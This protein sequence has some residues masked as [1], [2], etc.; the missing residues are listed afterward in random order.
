MGF[1]DRDLNR[2]ILTKANN[3]IGEAITILTTTNYFNDDVQ[4]PVETTTSTFIGPLSKEQLEQQQQQQQAVPSNENTNGSHSVI[5][6]ELT[7]NSFDSFT[8]NA[9]LDL[10]TKVYGDSWSIPYKREEALG[11]C[12]L[13]ATKLAL[14]G[15]ADQDKH[16]LKFMENLIPEAFRKLQ[17]SYH[18]N[19]WAMEIQ[20][21]VFDMVELVVDL[22][23][24]RLAYSPVPVKLLETLTILFDYDSVFQRKHKSKT[25]DRSL[26]DKQL[27]DRTLAS[28][29]SVSAFSVYNRN[30][31]YG[32]LCQ[33]IN[34]FVYKDGLTNLKQQFQN[35][36]PLTALEYNALLSPFV[37]C[38]DYISLDKY[39]QLFGEHIDQALEYIINLK[40]EDFKAKSANSIFE[41]LTTLRNICAAA[42]HNR[43]EQVEQLHLNLLLKMIALSNFNAKMNSLKELAKII[44]NS[45][46]NIQNMSKTSIRREVISDWIIENSILSKALEGNIDQNQYVDKVRTLLDFIATKISKE[47]IETIWKMQHGRSLVAVDHLFTLIASAAA[48]FN[49]QQL[50]YLIE[51]IYDS[52]KIETILI[53]EKLIELLGA[54]GRECQKESAARVLEILWDMAHEEHL[55]RS[56]LDNIL[57]CHLRIFSE[58]RSPYDIL[59]R[60]YCLKC[61]NDLQRKQGWLAPAIKHL[62]DLLRH[63]STNTFKR[64]DQ[65][66]ISV[67]VQNHDLISALIQSLSTCQLD[68]WN[69]TD[70]HVT[71]DTLVDGRY[72]HEESTRNHLDLLSFLLKKGNLFLILKRSEELWDTLITNKHVNSFDHE[73]GLNWFITCLE[74]LN[75]ESQKALFEER[76]SKLDPIH[77]SPKGYACFKL[78]F[79]R[80]ESERGNSTSRFNYNPNTS[81]SINNEM[82]EYY[83]IN[84]LWNIILCVSDDNLANEATRFLLDLYYLKQPNRTRRL[85]ATSLHEYFLK[86]VYTRLS[87]LLNNA[88]PPSTELTTEMEQFYNSLKAYGEQLI[89]T[90]TT[91]I[92]ESQL[93]NSG[94]I[95]HTLWL[96]K[97]ERLLMITEEY[98]HIVEHEHSPTAHI[99]SFYGLEYQIK[100]TLDEIGKAISSYDIVTVHSNDTLEMLR[101]RLGEFYK[102]LSHDIHISIQNTRPLPPSYDHIGMNSNPIALPYSSNN[103]SNTNNNNNNNNNSVLGAWLNSKYLYQVH[104]VPGTTI[105]IKILGGTSNQPI[106]SVN[107]E[108]KRIYLNDS[109]SLSSL[110]NKNTNINPNDDLTRSIPSNMMVENSKIYD[111]LYTLSYLNNKNIHQ[112]IRN[113]LCLIPSDTRTH[114]FLDYISIRAV[115]VCTTERRQSTENSNNINPRQAIEHVFD[116]NNCSFIQLLYNLEILS[117]KILPLST[118]NGIQESSKLFRQDFIEQSGVDFLFQLLNSLTDFISNEYQYTLC[119]EMIIHILQLIQLLVCGNNINHSIDNILSSSTTST[120]ISPLSSLLQMSQTVN[121]NMNETTVD[122]DFQGTVENLQFDTFVEQIKQLIFLCWAAAAGNIKLH[123]QN[124]TI[125]EEVKLDRYTLLQQIN[126]NVINRNNSKNSLS[127]D[128]SADN[129]IQQT[130][131][132]GICVKK[133]SILPLDSEIAEKIIEIIT[134][135]FEKRPEFIATFLIQSFFADYLLEILIGTTSR[136]VRQCAL[137]NINR[138]CKIET[139]TYDIRSIIHQILLKARL[140]LWSSSSSGIRNS[141]QKILTQS[142]EYFDLR[143]QLTENLTIEKQEILNINAKQLLK[144]E[145]T[146]LSTYTVSLTSNE[147]RIIDNILFLGHL[148]FIRTL[149]T[150]ENIDKNE[151]GQDFIRLL[152]D[153][154]LFPASKRM[155]LSIVPSN[156]E[157]DAHDDYACE[158]KCSTSESRLAAYDVLVELVRHCQ[159]NLK[160][161]IE[162]LIDLHHRP[163]LEKQTEWEFMPQVNPRASCGLVGLQNGGATCYMNSILQQLY[164]LPQISEHILS[165]HDDGENSNGKVNKT[166]GEPSLFYQLQQV[167][168]H[169]MESKLQYYSPESL[170]KV[171]RLWGQEINVREQQDAFDFFTAMTDQ[172]DEYLKSIKQEE[173]FHKQFEG[174]FCN[175]MICTNGCRHRYEGEEKF[176]A[177]NVAVK[178]DSL[179]ESLNQFVKGEVLDGTNA[180]FCA[181]CQEKRTTI[182]RLCIKKLPPL[183]CIQMKRFGF[184]WE[185][186]RALKFDDYFK[187]PLILNMEPYTVDG[188]N[189]RES[190]VE[191]DSPVTSTDT[192]LNNDILIN[193][194]KTGTTDDNP[195]L[196][197]TSSSLNN[198][199]NTMSSINYELIGIVI[200]S[201]Q[202]NAGHYYSFIKDTRC[203]YSNNTNQWYRFN[204]TSVEEIQLTEQMLE[205]ECF[206]GTFRVQ[207][208]NHNNS[209]E[210]RTRFWNAYILIYQCIE[211]SKL[212]PPPPSNFNR[213]SSRNHHISRRNQRDSLS[214]LADLVV[215]SEHNDLFQIKKSL[216]PS[217][218]LACVKDENLEFLKNRD[219]YCEDYFRFIYNLS[220]ICFDEIIYETNNIQSTN[221]NISSYKL[222]TKLALNFLF[223]THLRTHRRLRKNTLDDWVQLLSRLFQKNSLS[224]KIFY[225]LLFENEENRLKLYLLDC[226]IYEI[227]QI[228]E[229][230][231]ENILQ[232]SYIHDDQMKNIELFVEQLIILLDKSVVE[233][234]KHSQ[235]YFE[236]IYSYAN[237]NQISIEYLIKLNTFPRLMKFLLGDYID[238][239]RWNS[240]QAKEFGIIHEII[241]IITLHFYSMNKNSSAEYL[242]IQNEI[243]IY[244]SGQWTNR[245]LKEICYAFQEVS[246]TQLVQTLKL[247]ET[248]AKDN[249]Q[250]SEQLIRN[251]LLSISQAHTN[252]L[253][254]LFKLLNNI[255]L[256][257]DSFQTKRLQLAF[258]GNS[259]LNTKD[260]SQNFNGL[261][262]LI[263]T[264]I[265]TEQRRAYQT[266]KF[267]ITLSNKNSVCREY[268]SS[269]ATQWEAA[270]NWLKQQMQ[271]SW[272]LSPSQ[273]ISNED[274]DARS[275]QRT[276]SAQFTL[277]QAQSLLQLKTAIPSGN[278]L[279]DSLANESMESTDNHSQS[280]S[281]L[282]CIETE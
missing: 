269:T 51:F 9:F 257:E 63:D 166:D 227:R 144:D 237:M 224:C 79:E 49:L 258:E 54:I 28:P 34:R 61:M 263:Q 78:Y 164:M 272:Q 118:N 131:Q 95:D 226:P 57:Y 89:T 14:T 59:K 190:F 252:D 6:T 247:M 242:E 255:L 214:Q 239:R 184:D 173:I 158:P 52:W 55:S 220:N 186:N 154:F 42:W 100:I 180:Y 249:E 192:N 262:S 210:E 47:E 221:M 120:Q 138:L 279:N 176:M 187:F 256:I 4:I 96:Q 275:F 75:R 132:F 112:R 19:N 218:V 169:L 56:M 2:R 134:F 241:S 105:Y 172:I 106:K 119:Q 146:W 143:C 178:V 111:V 31:T 24:A 27:C 202:A 209:N 83:G 145:F 238:N 3:D 240:G 264:S 165:V 185:N 157:N 133:E 222:C 228:F 280:L 10:E 121:D 113:L 37:N 150:C 260:S 13:S 72:T 266:V 219:T 230:I 36:K 64:T 196:S 23:S 156:N 215:Q 35:E 148:K 15:T 17:C 76:V 261:Y 197:R 182:K 235:A 217:R 41:L 171:F 115:N 126:T 271:T 60:D 69:K 48:K 243:N 159:Q 44:E 129:N 183:L 137:H 103:Q 181:K 277:E 74:D 104:I 1:I 123:G 139:S 93:S 246:T 82:L 194:S 142:I 205:E 211:P 223:N 265:E 87:Y 140:P 58:G 233:Q 94:E 278:I 236:L 282:A 86:E 177:L 251:I 77:L 232:S 216:I 26:Y 125:K 167:F 204:D 155:S 195:S 107:T 200:H 274:N 122:L 97:I 253:K 162:D 22:I 163:L 201:G 30:E 135:C 53:Q 207:K 91:T 40:D 245:Y 8:T 268:F 188:V 46:S 281:Q 67:L 110:R 244:I 161:V 98:I 198:P 267:L 203:R 128:S 73:L 12:L 270:I 33:I 66:L 90:P 62:Y 117:S 160:L 147:L 29:P 175:Q 45:T 20:L 276:R 102:V 208:D 84:E 149:L 225:D 39:R 43:L 152:I 50:D 136:Q 5:S 193:S 191:Q 189:K 11:Q 70:G 259:E 254:S 114:D 18:V 7:I 168:G 153:Q 85:T 68:V 248:L 250:F 109:L 88:V 32:W 99:T 101:I 212:L 16:C 25:Y 116:I 65:D 206:G 170:W 38:M 81:T 174:I 229:R 199:L 231:C 92:A 151:F 179:N 273:N 141:N 213:L 130:V 80:C 234:I 21:G 127:N 71:I 108:P 124:L